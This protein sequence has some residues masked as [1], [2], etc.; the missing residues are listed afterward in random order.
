M[1]SGI[2]HNGS[3]QAF[4]EPKILWDGGHMLSDWYRTEQALQ[5]VTAKLYTNLYID[6]I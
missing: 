4:M 6:D 1:L 5:F 3:P 2:S